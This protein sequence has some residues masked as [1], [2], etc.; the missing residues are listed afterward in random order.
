MHFIYTVICRD[1]HK[2]LSGIQL[3]IITIIMIITKNQ[4]FECYFSINGSLK[5][6]MLKV[7]IYWRH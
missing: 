6:T 7:E 5:M 1:F 4:H 3:P 2:N